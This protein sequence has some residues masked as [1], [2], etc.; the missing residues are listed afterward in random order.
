MHYSKLVSVY[1]LLE[2]TP[3]RLQKI[4]QIAE[5]LKDAETEVLPKVSLL[6]Q[7][8]IFP[9]WDER[10][11]GV[12]KKM[13]IKII[14]QTTGFSEQDI[15][16]KYNKIGDLGLVVE[17]MVSKKR[18]K[19]FFQKQLTVDK[20]F[21]NLQKVAAIEGDGSV[22]RKV[23]LISELLTNAKPEEAKYIVRTV[24][25]ELRVGVAEGVLRDAI[26]KA[27]EVNP[28]DVENA[29]FILP[30]YGEVAKIAKLKGESGL[31]KVEI[32]LG[33]PINVLLA[34]KSPSLEEA[35]QTFEN[36]ALEFKF[37]GARAIIHKKGAKI[38][39]F[40]RRLEDVTHAFPDIVELVKKNVKA[41][42]CIL[43][44]E[45]VGLDP[46]TKKPVAFQALSTRIKRK[47]D[48][49]KS[50]KEI[51]VQ[52]NLFDIVYLDGKSLFDLPL[53]ERYALLKKSVRTTENFRLAD[54]LETKDL[55][56]AEKFYKKSLEEGE[57]GLIVKNMDAKYQPG[58]RVGYW[59][60]IKPTMENLD[61]VIVGGVHGTGKRT[62][63]IGSLILG[64]RDE[65]T[66]EFLEC[67]MLG[68]GIKEKKEQ[69]G[70]L[71]LDELTKMLKPLIISESGNEIKV[72]PKIVIEVAYEEIQKSPTYNS[73]FALRFPRFIS[74]RVEKLLSQ[75][76]STERMAKLYE[77]QKGRGQRK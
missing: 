2:K 55:K 51:P 61:L 27:F 64:C 11:I 46:K 9:S 36:V 22:E 70:D 16:E 10:V 33:I 48:I 3:A 28:V 73:G 58:R 12:A 30:D 63:W 23:S 20:V 54:H 49:E 75:V 47:Y 34:E 62:G 50:V 65:K 72:K 6:I 21:E 57:E 71:T 41:D 45:A 13:V 74:L 66:G 77:M 5:L 7:G 76:D 25:E 14:A 32:E 38:W 29:W 42:N 53:R 52:V 35:L 56:E 40:T 39:I 19:T 69:E 1:E 59:L 31:K 37:D 8:R 68:T 15:V 26:G 17:E 67:G 18:Q 43:D 4:D 44:S 60:K 24:L